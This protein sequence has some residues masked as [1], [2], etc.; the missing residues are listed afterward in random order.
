MSEAPSPRDVNSIDNDDGIVGWDDE[1]EGV[2]DLGGACCLISLE[3]VLEVEK[4]CIS[5]E[6][7]CDWDLRFNA[8]L[9]TLLLAVDL[10]P[11]LCYICW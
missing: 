11:Y 3:A 7:L 9:G 6:C 1:R 10:S 2:L 8:C 5:C 4:D